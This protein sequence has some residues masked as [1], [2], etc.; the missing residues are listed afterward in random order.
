MRNRL[1]LLIFF[2]L[3]MPVSALADGPASAPENL[4]RATISF[5]ELGEKTTPIRTVFDQST[6]TFPMPSGRVVR[7]AALN[8]SLSHGKKLRPELS[9]LTIVLNDEPVADLILSPENAA[10]STV[11]ID[12]PV[13]AIRP[14]DN[15]FTFRLNQ[16]LHS[17]GCGDVG[18]PNLWTKIWSSSTLELETVDAPLALDLAQLPAPFASLTTLADSPQLMLVLPPNPTPTELTAAAQIAAALGQ[19]SQWKQPPLQAVTVDQLSAQ[20]AGYHH[21]LAIDTAG[22]NPLAAGSAPGLSLRVSEENAHRLVLVV[23]GAD[24]AQLA[25]AAHMLATPSMWAAFSGSH[26]DLAPVSPVAVPDQPTQAT[27]AELG[28]DDRRV[29]GIG[30]HDLYYP[31]D[32]P[33]NWKPTSD[34]AIEVRFSHAS[35]RLDGETS[36]MSAF[37]N[38]SKVTD[39]S[40]TK[41]NDVNGRLVINLSPRQLRPGRNWLHLPFDLHVKGEDCGFRYLEEAWAT[42]SA[43]KSSVN[44]AHVNSEPP[45]ELGYLPS[46]LVTPADLSANVFVLASQPTSF[47]LTAMVRLAAK[48]GT[49]TAHDALRPRAT[50]SAVFDPAASAPTDHVIA[51]GSPQ[52][53][54]LLLDVDSALPQHL[55]PAET[56]DTNDVELFDPLPR[57]IEYSSGYIQ[58]LTAPWSRRGALMVFGAFNESL[59]LKAVEVFP[60][61]GQRLKIQG[62]VAV[63]QADQVIGLNIGTLSSTP[64]SNTTRRVLAG[65]LFGGLAVVG[66]AGWLA[67]HRRRRR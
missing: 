42:I 3:L 34:A 51:I 65:V 5:T 35:I 18:D 40:L 9:D 11:T 15:T 12:L 39:V 59:L 31:I 20:D 17:K 47:E 67:G 64:L 56:G 61:S 28:F 41:R 55:T 23:S 22:R 21:L 52:S 29:R 26:V 4:V 58:V 46:P 38:G 48:L 27:F 63:V 10:K 50:T 25:Q 57:G 2:L 13:E 60:A 24:D 30:P 16:R 37:V 33:Y 36:T 54:G 49:Y 14:G 8:L 53:N 45:L 44:L 1:Y 7:R 6:V 43:E 66:G 19:Q 32:I 62:N